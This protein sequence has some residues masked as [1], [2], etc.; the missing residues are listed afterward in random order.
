MINPTYEIGICAKAGVAECI[1]YDVRQWAKEHKGLIIREWTFFEIDTTQ[2]NEEFVDTYLSSW[3][4]RANGIQHKIM[5]WLIKLSLFIGHK[6]NFNIVPFTAVL[7]NRGWLFK[8]EGGATHGK[9]T[10]GEFI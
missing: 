10:K 1:K 9:T 3:F 7:G 4:Q 2:K 5:V 6:R 8:I